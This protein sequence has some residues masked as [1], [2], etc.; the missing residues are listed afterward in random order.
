[1]SY[2][3]TVND[4][5]SVT[6]YGNP[7]LTAQA[8]RLA[9]RKAQLEAQALQSAKQVGVY[10]RPEVQTAPG[11][12]SAVT[13]TPVTGQVVKPSMFAQ[14]APLVA[15]GARRINEV[16]YDKDESGYNR[17]EQ[18]AAR[19]HMAAMPTTEPG[20]YGVPVPASAQTK[21]AWAQAGQR[22]PSLKTTMDQYIADQVIKEPEREEMRAERKQTREDTIAEARRKQADELAYRRERD[23]EAADLRREL[24]EQNA[25]LRREMA[26]ATRAAAASGDAANKAANWKQE[27]GED[28]AISYYNVVTGERKGNGQ[29]KPSAQFAKDRL[30][31]RNQSERSQ[32]A[33]DEAGRVK[34]LLGQASGSGLKHD[35]RAA[36]NYVMGGKSSPLEADAALAPIADKYLKSVPRFEGPQSDADTKSYKEAAG[37]LANTKLS[38]EVRAAAHSEVVRLHQKSLKQM[39]ERSSFS[40]D[41]AARKRDNAPGGG[42]GGQPSTDSLLDKYA[43]R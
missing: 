7:D 21:L 29:G 43:P 1:M 37:Q 19:R 26:A 8:A 31:T 11:W 40:G 33:V 28:G 12:T 5:D 16:G 17:M 23:K 38:P 27:T 32:E 41:T 15:E 39:R 30:E 42:G 34:E 25:N 10:A 20:P 14:L 13:G 36:Y 22:I 9:R 18:E 3:D 6:S 35:V 4:D 24:A 2:A